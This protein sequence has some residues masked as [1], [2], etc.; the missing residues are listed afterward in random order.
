MYGH[1]HTIR[2]H[3]LGISAMY[4]HGGE[5]PFCQ[6]PPHKL[7]VSILEPEMSSR[8]AE[9]TASVVTY[10][11]GLNRGRQFDLGI[12]YYCATQGCGWTDAISR[13]FGLLVAESSH[14][15]HV[16]LGICLPCAVLRRCRLKYLPSMQSL[17]LEE[18]SWRA[19]EIPSGDCRDCFTNTPSLTYVELSLTY[20]RD[21]EFD[22]SNLTYLHLGGT[23]FIKKQSIFLYLQQAINLDTLI[24]GAVSTN[25]RA[26]KERI[27]LPRLQSW[28]AFDC[29]WLSFI[30]APALK[31]LSVGFHGIYD[32]DI[33]INRDLVISFLCES[34]CKLARLTWNCTTK[35]PSVFSKILRLAPELVHIKL[36]GD[37][38]IIAAS[39][40]SLSAPIPGVVGSVFP[41]PRLRSLQINLAY[42]QLT[43]RIINGLSKFLLF[44]NGQPASNGGRPAIVDRVKWLCVGKGTHCS[45]KHGIQDE[46]LRRLCN[47]FSVELPSP[48]D[49][50]FDEMLP[51]R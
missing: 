45:E 39:I 20:Y 46:R 13:I 16:T 22:W 32:N 44:R 48:T 2:K 47:A 19:I 9:S 33:I 43:D 23:L 21:W 36:L 5:P 3:I 30:N 1:G 8:Q 7:F 18:T 51:I 37:S 35:E 24:T 38:D 10:F 6:R 12:R 17:R 25:F 42:N 49:A 4:V 27:T 31:N 28:R 29:Y 26:R 15:R 50:T 14:W 11:L 41:V 40:E 34:D